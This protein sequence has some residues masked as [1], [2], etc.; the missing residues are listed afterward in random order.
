MELVRPQ[1]QSGVG[2]FTL[3]ADY[4]ELFGEWL[5]D[6]D[7]GERLEGTARGIL[8]HAGAFTATRRR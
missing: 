6:W 5:A 1:T 7:G 2:R 4:N 3:F 8:T